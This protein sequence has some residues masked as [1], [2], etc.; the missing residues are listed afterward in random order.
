MI[1]G[2]FYCSD[3]IFL[4][5]E[6]DQ[7]FALEADL[8]PGV[9]YLWMQFAISRASADAVGSQLTGAALLETHLDKVSVCPVA[10][11]APAVSGDSGSDHALSTADLRNLIEEIT[12]D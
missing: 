5:N 6:A 1:C 3:Q 2:D 4:F 10:G 12:A 9:N 11:A 7:S 8:L